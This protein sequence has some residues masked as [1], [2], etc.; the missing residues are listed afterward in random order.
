MKTKEW[1]PLA[2][3]EQLIKGHFTSTV[4]V[5]LLC[6]VFNRTDG[7]AGDIGTF[8]VRVRVRL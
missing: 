8:L 5:G 7:L 4:S 2:F 6:S 1:I 3:S